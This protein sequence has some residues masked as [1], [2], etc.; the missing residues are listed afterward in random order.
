MM[1]LKECLE[2]ECHFQTFSVEDKVVEEDKTCFSKWEEIQVVWE[3]VWVVWVVWE[4]W[5][6]SIYKIYQDRWEDFLICKEEV[7]EEKDDQNV[8][9]TNLN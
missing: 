1:T 2:E 4:V 6:V 9:N 7:R 5:G 3:E 8:L